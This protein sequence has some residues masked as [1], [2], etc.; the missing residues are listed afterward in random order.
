MKKT[1]IMALMAVASVSASAQQKQTIEIP[2][3]LSN[4]KLSGYGMTQYQ[5]SGQK[6]AESNSFNIRMA[7]IALEGR[8]AGDFYWK[9]Q[10]QFNG[11]TSNLGSSPRMVDLFAEWQ[12]YEYFKVKV[13]QFKNPFTFENPMHPIDQGFMGYSQ[14][15]SKLAGFSDRAG[16]HASNGRD[17]GLQFQG[18]FL[19]NANGRNLLHYQIGVFNGQG[20]NTKDVDNQKN[21]IGG[22]WVMPISGMRIGAFGWTGSYARKGEWTETEM[23][24]NPTYGTFEEVEVVHTNEVRKLAQNRYAFSFEYK[25][26][27][28]TVRSEYI[29]STGKAFAKSITNFND[30]NAKDCSINENIGDK[31]QGVYGLVIAPLAQ[32]PKNSRID[33]K[34][35]YDMYQ[36]NGKS[37]MQKTQY[38]AGLNFHI[39]KRITILTEYAL[40][41]DKTLAKHN[42]SMADAEFCFRF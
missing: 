39:G 12:K 11:N 27:G 22:V 8:I 9:T 28:W 16:E 6:D 26:D 3:W 29:H 2:S 10:I 24:G 41:N 15:V 34:A 33:I 25:K 42:Y 21:V 36:P 40:V 4:V 20:T 18:D 30:A 35:R 31:A 7:R 32:L 14:N 1:I 17:I 5:Y 23:K 38:E 19:K 37:N 13:G